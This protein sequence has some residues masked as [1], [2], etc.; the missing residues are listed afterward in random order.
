MSILSGCQAVL[1]MIVAAVVGFVIF[2]VVAMALFLRFWP[3][4]F[5]AGLIYF[6]Y[7]MARSSARP[8]SLPA[9]MSRAPASMPR[10]SRVTHIKRAIPASEPIRATLIN[11]V[12]E[13]LALRAMAERIATYPFAVAGTAHALHPDTFRAKSDEAIAVALDLTDRL[14]MVLANTRGRPRSSRASAAL[15]AQRVRMEHLRD[16][17]LYSRDAIEEMILTGGQDQTD[18]RLAQSLRNLTDAIDESYRDP[19]DVAIERATPMHPAPMPRPE[20]A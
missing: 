13:A 11:V 9:P 10:E 20:T 1:W 2:G 4:L 12:E 6:G 16:A 7:R 5:L 14:H 15:A 18:G 19:L 8:R 3:L 17:L